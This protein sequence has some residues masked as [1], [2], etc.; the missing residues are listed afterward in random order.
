MIEPG[1]FRGAA[2]TGEFPSAPDQVASE[3][4]PPTVAARIFITHTRPEPLLGALHSVNTGFEN[5][6]ALGFIGRG[7]TLNTAGML[8]VNRCSWAHIVAEASRL[9]ALAADRLLSSDELAVLQGKKSPE[10]VIV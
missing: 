6:S 5:T 1:R 3:L 4:Y 7:G 2:G 9:L 8:F 10:G